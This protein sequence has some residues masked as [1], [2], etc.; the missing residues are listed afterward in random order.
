MSDIFDETVGREERRSRWEAVTILLFVLVMA[1]GFALG[2][3]FFTMRPE[4]SELEK[5]ELT[6]F[7]E[8]TAERFIDGEFCSG[9]ETWF[10]DT[11][12]FREHLLTAQQNL[13]SFYGIRTNTI[14]TAA[15]GD[16]VPDIDSLLESLAAE[17][18]ETPAET[19]GETQP[20][21]SETET[22]TEP[23]SE[24]EPVIVQAPD[25]Q[26]IVAMNPQNAGNVNIVDLVG[27]CVYGFN[28][29]AANKYC[30]NVA[31]IAAAFR[32]DPNVTV[33]DI[34]IPDNSAILL[35]DETKA[36]W[37]LSDETKVIQYYQGYLD[38]MAPEVIDVNI[39]DTLLQHSTE[40][41]YF[42]TDHHWTQL[43]AYYAYRDFCAAAGLEPHELEDYEHVNAGPFLG[44]YFTANGYTQLQENPDE[45]TAY[46]PITTNAF[47]FVDDLGNYRDGTIV[48]DMSDPNVFTIHQKYLSYL[49]GDFSYGYVENNAVSNGRKCIVI[50][51][52][53]G[54]CWAPFLVDHF[55]ELF[56]I[57][58]RYYTDSVVEL[59]RTEGVT[60][61][62]FIN[63]LEAISDLGVMEV[64]GN[65]CK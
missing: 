8:Y 40:Y 55:E 43:A 15:T 19:A 34:L 42:K 38:T 57:D 36:E 30:E 54:N 24:T 64:L 16:D 60:D 49:Y 48:R 17:E 22:E 35:D 12:P 62:V 25:G 5:R 9:V 52:S 14:S 13:Q 32:D 39:Y 59:A 44:S 58:Y 61:I 56:I 47:K 29:K 46:F 18:S 41:L 33:Y 23:S 21:S 20:V 6:K 51:E 11:F 31:S 50:K 3:I 45:L 65:I 27:Y 37:K 53:F 2:C 28:L 10:A 7:P 26:E 4:R 1:A 63:N